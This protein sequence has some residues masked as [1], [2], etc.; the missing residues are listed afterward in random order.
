MLKEKLGRWVHI[1]ES[2][3]ETCQE[4]VKKADGIME[5]K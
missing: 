4:I 2:D 5:G 1:G 3:I